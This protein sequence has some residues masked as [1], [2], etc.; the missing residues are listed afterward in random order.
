MFI[1]TAWSDVTAQTIS[2]CMRKA[3]F[4]AK[5]TALVEEPDVEELE[6]DPEPRD[7]ELLGGQGSFNEFVNTDNNIITS[8]STILL[9]RTPLLTVI[10]VTVTTMMMLM[11]QKCPNS[12]QL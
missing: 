12:V 1:A 10:L 5:Q 3:G 4:Y 8:G 9:R 7:W 11:F 2:N 6:E